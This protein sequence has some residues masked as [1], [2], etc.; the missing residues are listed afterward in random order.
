[1]SEQKKPQ[2][3]VSN[4]KQKDELKDLPN[5]Q[6]ASAQ[7]EQVKGGMMPLDPFDKRK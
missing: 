2:P 6:G 1:M 4:A 3:T 5:K 7:D